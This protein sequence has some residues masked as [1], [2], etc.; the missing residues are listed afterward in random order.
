M[1]LTLMLTPSEMRD[2]QTIK[3]SSDEPPEKSRLSRLQIR[4][5]NVLSDMEGVG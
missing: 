4:H 5:T 1:V 2:L 3:T